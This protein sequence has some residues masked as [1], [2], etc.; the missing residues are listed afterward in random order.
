MILGMIQNEA[1]AAL[2]VQEIKELYDKHTSTGY[3]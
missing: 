1:Q 2:A 3:Y